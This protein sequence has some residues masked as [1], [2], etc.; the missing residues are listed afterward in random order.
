VHGAG[1]GFGIHGGGGGQKMAG[2]EGH[3]VPIKKIS[4]FTT[5]KGN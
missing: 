3:R 2:Q 1:V 5:G 4:I